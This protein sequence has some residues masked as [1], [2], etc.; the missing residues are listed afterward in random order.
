[1][2]PVEGALLF[3]L[4]M[5]WMGG[6]ML[7]LRVFGLWRPRSFKQ[8]SGDDSTQIQVGPRDDE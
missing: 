8:V 5:A 7:S 3:V 6:I 4:G 1:M 2:N